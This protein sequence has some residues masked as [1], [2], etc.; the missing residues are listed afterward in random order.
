M[1][2]ITLFVDVILPLALPMSY[3]YRIPFELNEQIQLG[4]RVVVPLGKSKLYTAIVQ[5]IHQQPPAKYEAKYIESILDP[6]PIVTSKQVELWEWMASYYLCTL[7]EVM[8]A[9]L[10]SGLKLASESKISLTISYLELEPDERLKLDNTLTDKE[11]LITEALHL[12]EV[13]TVK[14]AA[15]I[16]GIKTI[17]PV[18]KSLIEKNIIQV[19]EELK[20]RF[21]VKKES[22][23]R[24]TAHASEEENLKV[25]FE[26]LE[27]KAFK[28]LEMLL[29][30]I[31]LSD[32]YSNS[33]KEVK[34]ALLIKESGL[35]L[36]VL[37][38]L[39]KKGVFEIYENVGDRLGSFVSEG[40]TVNLSE[41]QESA[42]QKIKAEFEK[43]EVV[44]LQGVTSSGKTEIYVKLIE[45]AFLEGKQV[46]YLL[47]EIALTT[48]II[49]RIRKFFGEAVGVYHSKFNENE[50]VEVWNKIL[51]FNTATLEAHE[52][53]KAGN[54]PNTA[55]AE[56]YQLLIGA[57]SSIFL[58]Y[59]NLGLVIVDKEHDSSYK[60]YEPAPRYNARDT[61][62]VLARLHKAKTLLGSATPSIETYYHASQKKYGIAKLTERYGGVQLPEIV[63]ADVKEAKKK[64]EM[65]SHFTP[66]LLEHI[67][68]ALVAKEQVILFQNRRG[69]APMLECT[70]CG[71]VPQC[72]QC[73]VSLTYHKNVNLLKCHYCGYSSKPPVSCEAC[74]S[75][76]LLLKG[77]GTEKVEEELSLFFPD[78]RVSRMDLDTTRSKYAYQQI[79]QSFEER[80]IDILVGTQMVTKGL[81][82]DNVSVVGIL[83]ADTM[84]HFPDFRSFERSYQLMAQVSGRAG[85]NTKRGK[86]IIQTYSPEHQV[87]QTIIENSWEAFYT[88]QL[89]ERKEYDYPP[90]HRLI[91]ITLKSK[92]VNVLNNA[93]LDLAEMLRKNFKHRV[94]GPEF[95]AVARVRNYFL[96]NIL[97]KLEK[98]I[99][100]AQAKQKLVELMG[101]LKLIPEYKSVIVLAD[102]D[103][104]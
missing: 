57:R 14:E 101:N 103:P 60:Q 46:L 24:L 54:V 73:D 74:G 77:F 3:T 11:F 65:K 56:K 80:N 97:L 63:I 38:E 84:L 78:A 27:K 12:K 82:F 81:D 69:F 31:K 6:S 93:A 19:E 37:N 92:D 104:L 41:H 91:R 33:P 30:F 15:E 68:N 90:F 70:T 43:K 1:E 39:I 102:V 18:I 79:L 34:K 48:Q 2:R 52:I 21:K 67:Q 20:E 8:N 100:I 89:V 7:G 62:M 49:N 86:V 87:I 47:P 83:N 50:R 17:Y 36:N 59:S 26:K 40:K 61:A 99:S 53:E 45:D 72:T 42:Y 35:N 25:I 55:N 94:L 5:K 58:P 16:L 28:Q 9:A 4:Q 22:F 64:K 76:E 95:P 88:A 71:W 10:P 29:T 13:V 51:N 66:L 98:E 32:R 75:S 23:V 85:R 44:L 96:K